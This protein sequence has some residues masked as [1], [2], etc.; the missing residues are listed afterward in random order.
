MEIS[1]FFTY[2][3]RRI[4][5]RQLES[6]DR[7]DPRAP[8]SSPRA[9]AWLQTWDFRFSRKAHKNM[10]FPSFSSKNRPFREFIVMNI[11]SSF[12]HFFYRVKINPPHI[13]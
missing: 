9:S 3:S 11:F 6:R 12:F 4:S 8:P 7:S 5:Y 13:I 10:T 1:R 2:C